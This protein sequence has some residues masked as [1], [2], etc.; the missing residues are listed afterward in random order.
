V[1]QVRRRA[2]LEREQLPL[3][4]R[5]ALVLVE[6][7][8]TLLVQTGLAVS[9]LGL[10]IADRSIARTVLTL[11]LLAAVTIS[12]VRIHRDVRLARRFLAEH[13]ASASS[14]T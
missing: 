12:T 14:P 6:Q 13:P 8:S 9:F 2:A 7:R 1:E 10:W 11:A 5:T 3:A 4:R